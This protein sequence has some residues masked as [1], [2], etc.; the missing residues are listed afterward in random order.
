M[1][2]FNLTLS[3][4]EILELMQTDRSDAFKQ[5]FQNAV[6]CFIEAES[7]EKLQAKPYERSEERTDSRNGTRDRPLNT[8]LGTIVLHVPRHR[9][10]PFHSLVFDNYQRTEQAL[11][12]T[13]A[14]MVVS[15]VSTRKVSNVMETLCGKE[16]SKSSVSKVCETL[17]REVAEFKN[18][19]LTA[20]YPFVLVDA[21]YFKVR[22]DHKILSKAMMIAVGITNQGKKEVL[23]FDTYANESKAT[24]S[25]FF[26][27][28]KARGLMGVKVITSDANEGILHAMMEH[29]PQVPWQRCHYHFTKNIIDK[30]PKKYVEGLKSE[31]RSLLTAPNLET[32]AKK[33]YQI[34]ED[35]RD[36]A[37]KAI[38]CLEKGFIDAMTNLSCPESIRKI[39]RTSNL[40]ERL[41]RE[42]KRRSTVIGIFPN[43]MSLQRL[44]GSVLIEEH[45][46][47]SGEKRM[48]YNPGYKA[49]LETSNKLEEIAKEQHKLLKAA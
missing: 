21:T 35:Y 17:D 22:E 13:M 23:G 31:I 42:L 41:N 18:R 12:G 14:E 49:L 39:V 46:K 2:E 25:D 26:G 11:I 19:R 27:R 10:E 45:D 44:M 3:Q 16:F 37:E 1:A 29:F 34:S 43:E 47:W 48:F 32:A 36:V 38:E 40:V 24:W 15:G 6:N 28:L 33:L 9:N 5:L 30:T 7:E 4:A 20:T 8:R